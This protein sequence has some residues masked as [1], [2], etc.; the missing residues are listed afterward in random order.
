MKPN[1]NFNI[2]NLR[3][4]LQI[5]NYDLEAIRHIVDIAPQE[6]Q[7][8]HTVTKKL[9]GGDLIY[10]IEGMYIPEQWTSAA[11]VETDENMM[12]SFFKEI[13]ETHGI[14]KVNQ[15]IST[16][17]CW[18]HSHHTMGVSP[19]GQDNKQFKT[20]CE[21]AIKDKIA[22]PQIMMIFNKSDSY[23]CRI[24]DPEFNLIFENVPMV[25]E[26]YDF[27]SIDSQAK[28]KFKKK[29]LINK[30]SWNKRGA[31]KN[32]KID[33]LD[34]NNSGFENLN[35]F[36]GYSKSTESIED[37][38]SLF[39]KD[40]NFLDIPPKLKILLGRMQRSSSPKHLS[41][42]M[43][44][45]SNLTHPE[46]SAFAFLLNS[47]INRNSEILDI[48]DDPTG[49]E[50]EDLAPVLMQI[51]AMLTATED[52]EI[53]AALKVACNLDYMDLIEVLEEFDS[54]V[55]QN[56]SYGTLT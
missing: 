21:N 16:M 17:T 32:K 5:S 51:E 24:F 12:V 31:K 49:P 15:I 56:Q 7:W 6:A 13:R 26:A 18:C 37:S 33:L 43:S 36:E 14:E 46:I 50:E 27:S 53:E 28:V 23:Y 25:E 52:N 3:P 44:E 35:D 9:K 42:F 4:R 39:Q 55:V 38:V 20:Q 30:Y 22:S 8:Y 45:V 41:M 11:S 54:L 10:T 47:L 48:L 29:K 19:S 34:W 1:G 2:I 40:W